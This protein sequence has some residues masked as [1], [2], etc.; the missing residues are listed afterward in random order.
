MAIACPV[1]LDVERLRDE[2]GETYSRLVK[3][4]DGDFHFHHGL[5]YACER[6]IIHMFFSTP[7]APA[8]FVPSRYVN[9]PSPQRQALAN[10]KI[11]LRFPV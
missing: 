11:F 5:D 10:L 8:T 2:V 7:V 4:P 1:N 6:C 9:R 3:E